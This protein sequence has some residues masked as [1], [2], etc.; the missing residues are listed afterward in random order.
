MV[1]NTMMCR[2]RVKKDIMFKLFVAKL[3]SY[4]TMLAASHASDYAINHKLSSS[5]IFLILTLKQ[6]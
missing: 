5:A 1:Y 4:F 6:V 3:W 2:I